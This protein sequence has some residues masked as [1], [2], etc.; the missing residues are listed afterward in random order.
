[1]CM[2]LF[3]PTIKVTVLQLRG[4]VEKF[5]KKDRLKI[6]K[7]RKKKRILENK[8]RVLQER[9]TP[10]Y[11]RTLNLIAPVVPKTGGVFNFNPQNPT[12]GMHLFED[13][14]QLPTWQDEKARA[15]KSP[16][17]RECSQDE[18]AC[19]GNKR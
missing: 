15:C 12:A 14:E 18:V 1:M 4:A 13:G 2:V 6:T 10:N 16:L 5:W 17:P 3:Y 7:G 19:E 11:L 8:K 9:G